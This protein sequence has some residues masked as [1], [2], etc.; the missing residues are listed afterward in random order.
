MSEVEH[1]EYRRIANEITER[2][3]SVELPSGTKLGSTRELADQ[4]DVSTSTI[5]RAV[6]LLRDRG[7]VF[8]Q[9]GKGVYVR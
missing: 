2:I 4:Y 8:G 5:Y 3:R 7:L 9:S 1:A 6:A